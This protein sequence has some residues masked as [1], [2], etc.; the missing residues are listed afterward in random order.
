LAAVISQFQTHA[1]STGRNK[2]SSEDRK[3]LQRTGAALSA[4]ADARRAFNQ[5]DSEKLKKHAEALLR[6]GATSPSRGFDASNWGS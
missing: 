1:V 6:L 2:L 5:I 3:I 4:L